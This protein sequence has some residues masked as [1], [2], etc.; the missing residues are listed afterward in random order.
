MFYVNNDDMDELFRNASEKYPL[1]T[2]GAAD[3]DKVYTSLHNDAGTAFAD[4]GEFKKE[5]KRRVFLWWI[6]LLPLGWM[7]HDSWQKLNAAHESKTNVA[8]IVAE[9]N[10][11]DNSSEKAN[12]E[13]A[14][15]V[16][17]VKKTIH[18]PEVKSAVNKIPVSSTAAN[19]INVAIKADEI[20]RN[21]E[22]KNVAATE[23][24]R[25]KKLGAKLLTKQAPTNSKSNQ[26][27]DKNPDI[28]GRVAV[29][30]AVNNDVQEN[31][32]IDSKTKAASKKE[33]ADLPEEKNS[34]ALKAATVKASDDIIKKDGNHSEPVAEK[35]QTKT[36][37]KLKKNFHF[38]AA[39]MVGGD[40]STVKF[41]SVKSIG[42][43][44]GILLGYHFSRSRFNIETG[45]F[46]DEK[47]YYT[48]G[49]YFNASKLTYIQGDNILYANG[50]CN[51]FEIPIN[52]RYNV[53]QHK[54]TSLFV[55]TG[56][57]SYLMNKESY[58]FMLEQ[59]GWQWAK[60]QSYY[61]ST[62]NWFSILNLSAGYEHH[63][64]KIG[65]IR[66]EPYAK[67]PLAGV[68]IGSLSISSFGLNVGFSKRF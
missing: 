10:A 60:Q 28:K 67:L 9:K 35:K 54:S 51:M 37:V 52:V 66:I 19:K 17:N 58:N 20:K 57:S 24:S 42:Y 23:N 61:H 43:S 65:D 49:E 5:K 40:I 59:N 27:E 3:W 34:D 15:R 68:G 30:D 12:K 53:I 8:A 46:W 26:I 22:D 45:V 13:I 2:E 56:L 32:I 4:A 47:K 11:T 16:D 44:T 50:S 1:K 41:Q 33:S 29:V 14:A 64:G 36:T 7:G 62:Q 6:L 63:L 55:A 38:Y 31:N 39:L 21:S 48:E 25:N 18:A